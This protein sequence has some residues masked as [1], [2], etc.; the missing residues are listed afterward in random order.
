MLCRLKQV[1]PTLLTC[2]AK[3]NKHMIGA[4]PNPQKT[5]EVELPAKELCEAIKRV[6][7]F[8]SKY[9]L[10][11]QNDMMKIYTFSSFEFLSMGAHID[12]SVKSKSESLSDLNFE[13]RRAVGA[14]D[15]SH[16]V[17]N[18]NIHLAALIKLVQKAIEN[19][20]SQYI[21]NI[22]TARASGDYSSGKPTL[23][24][25]NPWMYWAVQICI[26]ML[27]IA[28]LCQMYFK[29]TGRY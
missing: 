3:N 18:A 1:I 9:T 22:Q 25:R 8:T 17:A 24:E 10:T 11:N 19:D 23:K 12:I 15:K 6:P 27:V 29:S 28:A 2:T 14:F 4:I 26:W 20:S 13:V 7:L 16:E 21:S 5:V